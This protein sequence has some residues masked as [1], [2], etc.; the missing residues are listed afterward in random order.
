MKKV[1]SLI[2]S[3]ED[4]SEYYNNNNNNNN[5]NRLNQQNLPSS[6]SNSNFFI[7]PKKEF[8]SSVPNLQTLTKYSSNP[9]L[10]YNSNPN[11]I[12][13]SQEVNSSTSKINLQRKK[14]QL[15]NKV[16]FNGDL[17]N[18]TLLKAQITHPAF[19]KWRMK[20]RMKTNCVGLVLCLNIGVDPPDVVKTNP[21]ARLECWLDPLATPP[22]KSVD[23]IGKALESQYQRWQNKGRYKVS[24][25]PTIDDVKKLCQS[26]RRSAKE[27]RVLIHYNAHGVPKPTNNGEI[28][29]FNKNYTQ[30]IPLSL[31]DL[32]EWVLAPSIF[33]FDCS[34]A[35]LIVNW[36]LKFAQQRDKTERKYGNYQFESFQSDSILLVPCSAGETLP[37]NAELPADL[38]TCCLTTPIKMALRWF[39]SNNSLKTLPLDIVD[40]VTGKL[41]ERQ[42]ALGELN[43]IFT[44]VTDTI[45]WSTLQQDL[46]KKLFRQDLLVASLFRNFLLAERILR[47]CNCTPISHPKLPATH[48]H[49]LWQA[50][51]LAV[52]LC[53]SQTIENGDNPN[54]EYKPSPFFAEQLTA[55]ELWL[56]YGGD[57]KK[58]P[59]HLPIVLQTLLSPKHRLR[60]LNL[61]GKFLDMGPAAVNQALSVGIFPYVLKLLLSPGSDLR[62]ILVFIWTKVLAL[63]KSCQVDIVKDNGHLYFINCLSNPNATDLKAMAA[64]VLSVILS[65]HNAGQIACLSANLITICLNQFTESDAVLRKWAVI[66]LAK[67]WE[68]FEDA[69]IAAIKESAQEKICALLSDSSPE[70][71]TA[72]IFAIG[73]FLGSTELN[74]QR[75]K[76]ELNLALTLPAA[77]SDASWMVRKELVITMSRLIA[78]HEERFKEAIADIVVEDLNANNQALKD[79]T[80]ARKRDSLA[81]PSANA[82]VVRQQYTVFAHVWRVLNTLCED[83]FNEVSSLAQKLVETLKIKV[84]GPLYLEMVTPQSQLQ[85]QS[86]MQSQKISKR[87]SNITVLVRPNLQNQ[88]GGAQ[89]EQLSAQTLEEAQAAVQA[90]AAASNSSTNKIRQ[91]INLS[92]APIQLTSTLYD[93]YCLQFSKPSF[94]QP[95][96]S[97]I[98]TIFSD[99]NW[100]RPRIKIAIA[101]AKELKERYSPNT[102][103]RIDDQI[104]ILDNDSKIPT[105]L[106]FHPYENLLVAADEIDCIS[107]WNWEEHNKANSFK[108]QNRQGVRISS[109]ALINEYDESVLAI[110]SDDGSVKLWKGFKHPDTTMTITSWQA[111]NEAVSKT[112]NVGVVITWQQENGL[113]AAGG[114]A[115]VIRVWDVEK[116]LQIIDVVT[117]SPTPV[118]CLTDDR[119]GGNVLVSGHFDGSVR[120]FDIRASEKQNTISMIEHDSCVVNVAVPK[121][122]YKIFS[123][124]ARGQI[125]IWDIRALH[126]PCITIKGNTTA[127]TCLTVHDYL[128]IIA[129]GSQSQ[130]VSFL[131]YTGELLNTVRY[132]DGFL[133]QRVGPISCISF[134][135]LKPILAAGAT[136]SIL[137]LYQLNPN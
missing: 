125:K 76:I 25:D 107:I 73:T 108:N 89:V 95:K 12:F 84:C 132:H 120:L 58:P 34:S 4:E 103:K 53:L 5:N 87:A 15:P 109:L 86:Q 22:Q 36:F 127:M 31:H 91:S 131:S 104:A 78:V 67:L 114:D 41:N 68:N 42:T 80:K 93:Y 106:M 39:C 85:S 116:E 72:V 30:Y 26:L 82:L 121:S 23:M 122:D 35:G 51:D 92:D 57:T 100:R 9:T 65:D 75:T 118:T 43:W 24:L 54:Y 81:A 45:A 60:A 111:L 126:N 64:F 102:Q 123:G 32:Q 63:D 96:D 101:E 55:F 40:K 94:K 115:N 105:C 50:W 117:G 66:C 27:E 2:Q 33:V 6:T 74:E 98:P 10:N 128:P 119:N 19:F 11:P 77:L 137:S 1:L 21:C 134:H 90:A 56:D 59:M 47:A 99:K 20:D 48:Q 7:S 113:L 14:I 8:R 79:K 62:R 18:T 136:D 52:D 44:A 69:K 38:F 133:G 71:R 37:M 61:L 97:E 110:A 70:V 88:S 3:T 135:P 112:R 46:F 124:T 17:F 16:Y 13:S 130:K 49:P 29:V 129:N 28:W 83:P